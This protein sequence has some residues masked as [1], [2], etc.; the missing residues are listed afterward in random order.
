MKKAKHFLSLI[1]KLFYLLIPF[2]TVLGAC[3][4]AQ[5]PHT[6]AVGVAK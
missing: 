4:P 6:F 3:F 2:S 1:S 5:L